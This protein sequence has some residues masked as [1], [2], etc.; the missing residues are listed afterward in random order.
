MAAGNQSEVLMKQRW[1]KSGYTAWALGKI[2]AEEA[3]P[4][5]IEAL[6]DQES[7]VRAYVAQAL[8]DI[9]S[10]AK[11]AVPLSLWRSMTRT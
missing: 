7:Y 1:L 8:G 10:G 5:L 9:G 11:D 6:N 4:A 3:V 2:G